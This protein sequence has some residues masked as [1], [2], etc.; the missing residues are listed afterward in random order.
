MLRNVTLAMAVLAAMIPGNVSA[1]DVNLHNGY[2]EVRNE[3]VTIEPDKARSAGLDG[4]VTVQ[5]AFFKQVAVVPGGGKTYINNCCIVAGTYYSVTL[6]VMNHFRL[7]E[8]H[9]RLCIK[10]G[11]PHGFAVVTFTGTV[12]LTSD[13][14]YD[15]QHLQGHVYTEKCP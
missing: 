5:A 3:L 4:T 10:N 7:V 6:R 14:H 13:N 9:P 8:V 2:I 11:I 15:L 1:A 12:T